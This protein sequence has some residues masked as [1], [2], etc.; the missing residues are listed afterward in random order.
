MYNFEVNVI[1]ILALQLDTTR[2]LLMPKHGTLVKITW[3]KTFC[4]EIFLVA[5][6]VSS[7]DLRQFFTGAF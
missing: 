1:K 5:H 2:K 4:V 6:M 3:H 7:A